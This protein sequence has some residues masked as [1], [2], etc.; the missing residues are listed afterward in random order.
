MSQDL[1]IAERQAMFNVL[2]DS[3]RI[4]LPGDVWGDLM[5]TMNVPASHREAAA[6]HISTILTVGAVCYG[7]NEEWRH[8]RASLKDLAETGA[9]AEALRNKLLSLD[10]SA[11]LWFELNATAM[12]VAREPNAATRDQMAE[13]LVLRTAVYSLV[14]RFER[15]ERALWSIAGVA[16]AATNHC[17]PSCRGRPPKR[18]LDCPEIVAFEITVVHLC[19]TAA[20]NGWDLTLSH[21]T[22]SGTLIDVIRIVEPHMPPGFVPKVLNIDRL[23]SLRNRG[24][25]TP[26]IRPF[27]PPAF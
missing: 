22:D 27:I 11:K 17:K 9:L 20:K 21:N 3:R 7:T 25:N 5:D 2:L 18:L 23:R 14:G 10:S 19:A 6:R 16:P 13:A 8:R 24:R 1:T 4:A 15:Y 26:E 12:E